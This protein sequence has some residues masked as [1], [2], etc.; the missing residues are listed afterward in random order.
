MRPTVAS[1]LVLP[2]DPAGGGRGKAALPS[3]L[4]GQPEGGLES[5]GPGG[6]GTRA[7]GFGANGRLRDDEVL[8]RRLTFSSEPRKGRVSCPQM[9]AAGLEGGLMLGLL[10]LGVRV[11]SA[12]P[13]ASCL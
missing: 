13:R 11:R 1:V 7:W 5:S 9:T 2:A 4:T 8:G 10:K 6:S 12:E 3:H